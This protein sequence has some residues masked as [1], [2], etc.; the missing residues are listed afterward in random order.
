M[1]RQHRFSKHRVIDILDALTDSGRLTFSDEPV[2]RACIEDWRRGKADL[3]D[4][5]IAALNLQAG[6]ETTVTFD[7]DAAEEPGFTLLPS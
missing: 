4:Y 7:E 1:G 2:I 3:P 5:L 6:A